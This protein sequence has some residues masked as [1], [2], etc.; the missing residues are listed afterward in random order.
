MCCCELDRAGRAPSVISF[1]KSAP[2]CASARQRAA[3]RARAASA[4]IASMAGSPGPKDF[5]GVVLANEVLDALPVQRFRIRGPQVNTVGV[6]WQLGRLDWSEVRADAA[7]EAAVREIEASSG[8]AVARWLYVRDQPAIRAVDG[9]ARGSDARRRCALH[10][11]R[12][13]APSVLPQRPPR[14]HAAMPLPPSLS[15]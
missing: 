1:W 4:R 11:L 14:R 10:R 3:Q 7:L 2:I 15:R 9:G 13:A 6:T 8:R 12:I 5:R